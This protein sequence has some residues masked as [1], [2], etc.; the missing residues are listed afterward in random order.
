MRNEA[1]WAWGIAVGAVAL[2]NILDVLP[3]WTTIA[4]VLALPLA[5]RPHCRPL[6]REG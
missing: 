6:R 2:L 1:G 5:V 3:V 4:A